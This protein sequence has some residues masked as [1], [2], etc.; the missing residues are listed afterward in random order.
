MAATR[1]RRSVLIASSLLASSALAGGL[2]VSMPADAAPKAGSLTGKTVFLDPGHQGSAAGHDLAKQVPDG[3][4]GKKDCQTTGATAV[5]GKAEH[6]INWDVSQLVKKALEDKGAVVKMSRKDDTG[7]GGC[8]DERAAAASASGAQLAVS[9]HADSTSTGP[10]AAKSGFHMIVPTLPIPDKAVDAAQSTDGRKASNTIRDSLKKGGLTPA[11]Y[12]GA[13]DG[14]VERPDIA[15]L[16]LTRVPLA[17]IEMGNLSD[18]AE[19]AVLSSPQGATKY[20]AAITN[21]IVKYLDGD[22]AP[23]NPTAPAPAPGATPSEPAA[24]EPSEG[25]DMTGLE[26]LGPLIDKITKAKSADEAQKILMTE[27]QDVSSDVLRSMLSV[28]Y[29]LFGGELPV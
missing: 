13:V 11:N 29:A 7:W 8:V 15:G 3:R 23:A 10:D 14:I 2:L 5:T 27:G 1:A 12:L 25:V 19:A 22:S 9:I 24:P 6:T 26:G 18:P 20:A 4:D 28:V 16:N 17:F 21:G